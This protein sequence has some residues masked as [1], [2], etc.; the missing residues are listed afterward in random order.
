MNLSLIKIITYIN[1]S[2][3]NECLK[4]NGGGHRRRT[5]TNTMGG[6]ICGVCVPGYVMD[7]DTSCNGECQLVN[8][9]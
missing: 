1:C 7:G 4:N 6:R 3:V 5:C 8:L 9:C 2:D